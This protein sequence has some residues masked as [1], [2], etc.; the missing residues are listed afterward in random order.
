MEKSDSIG[1]LAEALAKAQ[2]VMT[3][4]IKDSDNPFFKSRYADLSSVWDA[5]RKPLTENG[6]AVIQTTCTMPETPEYVV[7][8][9]ILTHTSGEWIKGRLAMKPVKQDPQAIG[10]CITYARRYAL[11]AMVGIAPE[12]DDANAA[13]GKGKPQ[14]KNEVMRKTEAA[15]TGKPRQ[16]GSAI[17]CPDKANKIQPKAQCEG[18]AKKN[19]CLI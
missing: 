2:S 16:S 14:D 9:T 10:S 1:K 5:C 18:C 11:A 15:D 17:Y 12:D 6:L 3:G 13:S 7:V 19:E 4:A 8:E